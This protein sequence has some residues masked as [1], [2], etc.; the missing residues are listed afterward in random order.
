MPP[1]VKSY[2]Y[3]SEIYGI[4]S[5]VNS[6]IKL[7]NFPDKLNREINKQCGENMSFW[8]VPTSEGVVKST[9]E[10]TLTRKGNKKIIL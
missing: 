5:S 6:S 7:W 9:E 3:K 1:C 2:K 10:N 4:F 8:L